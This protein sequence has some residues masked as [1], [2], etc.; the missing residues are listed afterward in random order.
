[1]HFA[2]VPPGRR[3]FDGRHISPLFRLRFAAFASQAAVKAK[4]RLVT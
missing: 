2:A 3:Q 4:M 1:M